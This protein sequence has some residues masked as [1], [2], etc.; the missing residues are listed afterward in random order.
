MSVFGEGLGFGC[1]LKAP[2]ETLDILSLLTSWLLL[3]FFFFL[4][5]TMGYSNVSFQGSLFG[6]G[7]PVDVIP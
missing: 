2:D 6:T 5:R 1:E 7:P 3:L 4:E